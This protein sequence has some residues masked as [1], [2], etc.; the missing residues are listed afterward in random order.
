[1]NDSN[2]LIIALYSVFCRCA[3]EH[4]NAKVTERAKNS[5]CCAHERL[6]GYAV[7]SQVAIS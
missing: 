5:V 7:V 6:R 1:M 2:T 3:K 4:V